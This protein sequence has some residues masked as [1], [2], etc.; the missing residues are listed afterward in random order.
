MN[1]AKT[2]R[3]LDVA[4]KPWG[5]FGVTFKWPQL[6]AASLK[7]AYMLAGLEW[8]NCSGDATRRH[9]DPGSFGGAVIKC[10]CTSILIVLSC[11]ARSQK[12]CITSW[13]ILRP[14]TVLIH[15]KGV[16]GELLTVSKPDL[17]FFA[18]LDSTLRIWLLPLVF[19]N[20]PPVL[21]ILYV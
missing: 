6:Y 20:M 5:S 3:S 13:V 12:S 16:A 15:I 11:A 7:L 9:C 4:S 2:D 14:R 19:L 10:V 21:G 8:A 1:L 18:I 17:S